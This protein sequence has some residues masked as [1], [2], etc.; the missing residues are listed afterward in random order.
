MFVEALE[1]ED[2]SYVFAYPRGAALEIHHAFTRSKS[3]R[4]IL[5][6]HEQGEIL[7]AEGYACAT[8]TLGVVIAISSPAATNLVTC[9]VDAMVNSVLMVAITSQVAQK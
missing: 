8:G 4:I 3:I 9:L 1:L 5:A 2:V 7:L 6:R